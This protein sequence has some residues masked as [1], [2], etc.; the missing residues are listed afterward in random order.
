MDCPKCKSVRHV[1]D[2]IVGGRQRYQC[3][4]C[5]Y[6]YTVTFRSDV[7]PLKTRRLAL[8]LYLAGLSVRRIGKVLKISY[9]T[10]HVWVK[11]WGS[12][13]TLLRGTIPVKMMPPEK[14]SGYVES[15]QT[16]SQRRFLLTDLDGNIS[17]LSEDTPC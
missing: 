11:G 13:I 17:L 1:K 8:E 9:G 10:V 4:G 16:A 6:H 14:M 15:R 7:K 12:Q 5:G 2:G 3:K